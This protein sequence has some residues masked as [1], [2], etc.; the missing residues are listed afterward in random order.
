M[1]SLASTRVRFRRSHPLVA[2]VL[3]RLAL[4][5]LLIVLV[6]ML[7]FGA[8]QVL[9]GDAASAI[10]GRSATAE[11][12]ELY[13]QELGLDRSIPAQYWSWISGVVQGDLG[14][15]LASRQPVT[16]FISAR[17]GK[18][19]ILAFVTMIVLVPI[20]L[21]LGVWAGIRRDRAA[22]HVI[23]GVSLGLIALPEFVI[24]TLLIASIAVSLGLLPPTS[25]IES[26]Q[27]PLTHPQLLVLPVLTL[28][29]TAAAYI[30]RMMRAGV[31]ETMGADY[32]HMARLNG[33]PERRVVVH[34]ALRNSLAPTVQVLALTLQY[35]IGGLLIVETV[36]AYPGLGQGL[37]QAVTARDIPT[38]QG[39][40]I[41]L[42]AMYIV[43]N[44]V[45]DVLVVLL[46][47]KLRTS[48]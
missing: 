7:V 5:V 24:G 25:I 47:P 36:F 1:S 9:P 28:C 14:N 22:D 19:L 16:S 44:I 37:V 41:L 39:V 11:Q 45:A 4:G 31:G 10:L 46:V 6:S 30:I 15:S 8:T 3:R 23:S 12:K 32:V 29:L 26:G 34:H 35:L 2:F 18:S 17:I 20:A 27:S 33:V 21:A 48:Q 38:V 42:A 43:I 40:A 13:R